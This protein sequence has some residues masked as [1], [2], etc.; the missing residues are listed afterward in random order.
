MTD[1]DW[2]VMIVALGLAS[3]GVGWYGYH[4]WRHLVLSPVD[5]EFAVIDPLSAAAF[6]RYCAALL[7]LL[8]YQRVRRARGG[9]VSLT[10]MA[11]DGTLVAIRCARQKEQVGADAIRALHRGTTT[12]GHAGRAGILVT[13]ALVTPQARVLAND[14]GITVADRAVLRH[15]MELARG[16]AP[17]GGASRAADMRVLVAAVGCAGLMLT[18]VA[19]HT[20]TGTASPRV[21]AVGVAAASTPAAVIPAG[22]SGTADPAGTAGAASG[23]GR[24]GRDRHL[25][26]VEHVEHVRH[27]AF[28]EHQAPGQQS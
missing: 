28:I 27:V 16:G 24:T 6:T 13:N 18:A 23:D 22:T 4:R 21:A 14:T 25:L 11:P 15:W 19:V 20:A 17:A 5:L 26:H 8:G 10:A 12:G 9:A 7:R 3:A 2:F 1:V